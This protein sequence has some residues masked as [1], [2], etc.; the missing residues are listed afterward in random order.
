MIKNY[1]IISILKKEV[2]PDIQQWV[3]TNSPE[4]FKYFIH[5]QNS[6]ARG[7]FTTATT[8][9]LQALNSDSGFVAAIFWL[10]MTYYN[11]G[12]YKEGKK[13]CLKAYEKRDQMPMLEKNIVNYTHAC[14]FETQYEEIKYLKQ[15]IDIDE[16]LP[17]FYHDLGLDYN[18]LHQYDK[19]ISVL[20]KSLE[21]YKKWDSKPFWSGD[22]YS[23]GISY[24]KT[25]QY[26]KE[27]ELYKKAEQ[28][29]PDVPEL[30]YSQAVLSLTEGDTVAAN[31]YI[32]KYKSIRKENS[33]PEA[34][35]MN[36]VAAIYSESGILNKAEQYYRKALSLEPEKPDRLKNLAYFLI[37][38]D[39]NINEGLELIDKAMNLKPD[40]Y[41]Y[42]DNK[43]WGLYKQGKYQEAF[44]ILQKSWDLRREK[45]VYDY[46]AFLHLEAAKKAVANQK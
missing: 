32:E 34:S 31:R 27:K 43:G 7:D 22:Y 41:D 10:S 45:A 28:D 1:L 25:G 17:N 46:E 8:W 6:F 21:I 20:E 14:Y 35:I 2:L 26:K 39:R 19:A 3:S 24:H 9:Y 4:A 40:N 37:D 44:D 23:L 42:L 33:I 5:G 30:I 12:L 38:K 16:Q 36:D 18:I 29:F 15:I 13:L 11:Q